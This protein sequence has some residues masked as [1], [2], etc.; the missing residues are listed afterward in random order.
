MA[1]RVIDFT[2]ANRRLRERDE[3]T[4]GALRQ[5]VGEGGL[6]FLEAKRAADFRHLFEQSE[7]RRLRRLWMRRDDKPS[8]PESA[9]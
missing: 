9:A 4:A 1:A 3:R 7:A 5:R 8:G 2:E 6:K